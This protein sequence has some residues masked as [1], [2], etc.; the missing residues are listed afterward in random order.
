[1]DGAARPVTDRNA[2]AAARKAD[3][4]RANLAHILTYPEDLPEF[5]STLK[6][7]DFGAGFHREVYK[8]AREAYESGAPT[9]G[10]FVVAVRTRLTEDHADAKLAELMAR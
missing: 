9:D 4:E 1:M 3:I 5:L 6:D 8:A 10:S 7:T 2:A